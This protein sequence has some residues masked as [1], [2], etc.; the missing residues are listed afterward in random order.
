MF[1]DRL[2]ESLTL[3]AL[4]QDGI[5]QQQF[6]IPNPT[7]YPV[8]PTLAGLL[9]GAQPHAIRMTDRNWQA[10]MLL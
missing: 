9:G 1:Y 7:F 2:S 6:L 3:D 5:H 10:P 8:I 4:R